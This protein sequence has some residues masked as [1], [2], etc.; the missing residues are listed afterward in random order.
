[1]ASSDFTLPEIPFSEEAGLT[2]F[3]GTYKEPTGAVINNKPSPKF[4][5]AMERPASR[6]L[7]RRKENKMMLHFVA[8]RVSGSVGPRTSRLSST[9]KVQTNPVPGERD[10]HVPGAWPLGQVVK[11]RRL[12]GYSLQD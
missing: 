4:R 3:C 5:G 8:G 7:L 11:V 10:L 2:F 1:M 6:S 9:L 12:G